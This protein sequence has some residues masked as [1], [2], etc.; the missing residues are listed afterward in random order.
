MSDV[1]P[2]THPPSPA[3]HLL[4]RHAESVTWMARY[5]ERVE[6]LARILGALHTFSGGEPEADAG[7]WRAV[8][9]INADHGRF[10]LRHTEATLRTVAEFYLLDRDNPTSIPAA[11]D[12]V[13]ENARMLR[14]LISTEMWQQ[15]NIF[16]AQVRALT[17]ADIAPENFSGTCDQLKAG[18]QSHA[19]I[20][21]GT[22]YRDQSWDFYVLGRALERA[23]QTTRLLDAGYRALRAR[24][25]SGS[26]IGMM[27]WAAL[28]R[29]AAGYHAFRRVHPAGFTI[30]DMVSFLLLDRAF[31]RSV[32][33]NFE[34]IGQ[35]LERLAAQ[36]GLSGGSAA[37]ARVHALLRAMDTRNVEQGL[38]DGLPPFLDWVQQQVGALHDDIAAAFFSA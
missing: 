20:T 29:A 27:P 32:S 15:I 22:F 34:Q 28:L 11:M 23:D 16:H 13:R 7:Q 4:A 30:P 35:H 5:I 38:R 6:N 8:L 19:G 1:P 24:L 12:M 26:D 25:D 31:P 3:R 37:I 21:E 14:A 17:G 18:C 33:L 2:Q 9:R 10:L 36:H